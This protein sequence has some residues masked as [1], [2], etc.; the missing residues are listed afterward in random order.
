MK[1]KLKCV[2]VKQELEM[3]IEG[4]RQAITKATN[5]IIILSRLQECQFEEIVDNYTGDEPKYICV[6]SGHASGRNV[7]AFS[8][9]LRVARLNAII[10]Y[11][12]GPPK[13]KRRKR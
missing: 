3:M 10:E 7:S 11:I 5:E 6:I 13:V 12:N 4:A 2:S 9:T 1:T 8:H